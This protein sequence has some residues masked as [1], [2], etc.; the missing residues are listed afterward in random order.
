MAGERAVQRADRVHA[1]LVRPR[2]RHTAHAHIRLLHTG[3]QKTTNGP[4]IQYITYM[5]P[6]R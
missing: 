2:V 3:H 1:V 4:Y 5:Y 6:Y